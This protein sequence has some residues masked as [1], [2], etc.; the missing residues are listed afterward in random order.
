MLNNRHKHFVSSFFVISVQENYWSDYLRVVP[1]IRRAK[2]VLF[3]P[4]SVCVSVCQ[5]QCVSVS[6]CP[7]ENWKTTDRDCCNLVW[8]CVLC[9]TLEVTGYCWRETCFSV[10]DSTPILYQRY[11]PTPT[12]QTQWR[13]VHISQIEGVELILNPRS[14]T[15]I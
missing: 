12:Q 2:P 11:M 9:W 8:T 1:F 14:N 4:A 15:V 6:V 13:Q 10:F 5:C 3:L 7:R